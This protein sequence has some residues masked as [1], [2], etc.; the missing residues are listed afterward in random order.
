MFKDER[1]EGGQFITAL[2]MCGFSTCAVCVHSYLSISLVRF[3][4]EEVRND[5]VLRD[6]NALSSLLSTSIAIFEGDP[7]GSPSKNGMTVFSN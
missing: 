2:C 6:K 4:S 1:L 5:H 7:S 3:S